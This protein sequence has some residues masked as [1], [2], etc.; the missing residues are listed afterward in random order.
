MLSIR[1][2]AALQAPVN[3]ARRELL[4]GRAGAHSLYACFEIVSRPEREHIDSFLVAIDGA[5]G[6]SID[7]AIIERMNVAAPHEFANQAPQE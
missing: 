7:A 3:L 5:A 1:R 2:G 6:E 4:T